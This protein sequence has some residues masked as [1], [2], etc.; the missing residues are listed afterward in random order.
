MKTTILVTGMLL[1]ALLSC[2][3]EEIRELCL[4]NAE[5]GTVSCPPKPVDLGDGWRV[6]TLC[7]VGMDPAP[8]LDLVNMIDNLDGHHYEGLLIVKDNYLVYEKYWP[9]YE[10]NW[11]NTSILGPRVNYGPRTR[12]YLAS[13]SKSVTSLVFGIAMDQGLISSV[14]N[15]I[16]PY[17]SSDYPGLLTG[18]KKEI[19][20]KQ[21]LTM[22]S[23]LAWDE[24]IP[25]TSDAYYLFRVNDPIRYILSLALQHRP[26]TFFHYNSGGTNILG[27]LVH[28]TSGIN[29]REFARTN[30]FDPLQITNW[31]WK[32]IRNDH[33]FASGG[34]F[35]TPRD[36]I[37]L[38]QLCLNK[39]K[40]GDRQI[41]SEAWIRESTA[42]R[43]VPAEMPIGDKYGYQ[44]W[45]KDFAVDDE[46]YRSY[47]A[48]GW[49]E[50]YMYVFK[51]ENLIIL[52]TGSYYYEGPE[53]PIHYLVNDFI[54]PAVTVNCSPVPD[55]GQ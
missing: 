13:E 35:M 50:Q 47:F 6:E 18:Q 10:F 34:L 24:S 21:L 16:E 38:G 48:V 37:K 39:G 54:L 12:H 55:T 5:S 25:A 33:Y 49:G 40:W 51:K 22:S 2:R 4:K 31:E 52:F 43:I 20:I 28:R 26:G 17:Y 9:G 32:A 19:T 15:K 1:A 23:G 46:F 36:L 8:I 11:D 29:L 30:L 44:W 14:D 41:V 45:M 27:D 3:K 53:V 7:A 42:A